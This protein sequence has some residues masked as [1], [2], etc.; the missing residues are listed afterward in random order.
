MIHIQYLQLMFFREIVII[1]FIFARLR[2]IRPQ[3]PALGP[4]SP[5]CL[6]HCLP[7]RVQWRSTE[8]GCE[9]PVSGCVHLN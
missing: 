4:N 3:C 1:C 2:K 5:R 8:R 6:T 7:A 9:E